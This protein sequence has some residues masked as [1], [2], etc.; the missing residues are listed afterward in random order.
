[1]G[2][3]ADAMPKKWKAKV[4]D[5]EHKTP[6][7]A[8]GKPVYI[9]PDGKEIALD[10]VSMYQK[11]IDLG[12]ENKTHREAGDTLKESFKIFDDI[13]DL[14]EWKTKADEAIST[15]ENFNEK[16]W[17]KADK[18]DKLKAD[19]KDAYDEQVGGVKKSFVA[20]ENDYKATIGKKDNQIR[21]LM[22]S[23]KF[24]T[25]PFFSGTEPKTNLPPEIAETYFGKYF[26][27][28]E[29]KKTAK[30]KLIAYNDSGD[31]ILSR[32][33]PGEIAG[34]N[35]AMSFIFDS[36]SGKD[37]LLRGGKPGSGGGGGQGGTGSAGDDELE[38]LQKQ[39]AEAQKE[40]DSKAMI[41][42]KN[43]IFKI[44]QDRKSAAA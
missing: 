32:E 33:N 27:V 28:E 38:K 17:L 19:M 4:S 14:G 36:Y 8:D 16:D 24:A 23:N 7:F 30:L 1:M 41:V 20:K 13:D 5:D 15:V 12:K 25:S 6:V 10:P 3:K 18:V 37:K 11:I 35:E 44:Q 21:T 42:L 2:Q 26:K 31:Q 29:E 40:G 22:V 43:R 39:Y 34:F 9:D